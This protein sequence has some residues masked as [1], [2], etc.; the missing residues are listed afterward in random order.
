MPELWDLYDRRLMP[1]NETIERN[2]SMKMPKGKFHVV[3]NILSVNKE[4][5][6]LITKRHPDK[7]YG[8]MWE[9]SGG[10]VL[11]GER[12]LDGAVRELFEETGL[13][14]SADELSYMGQIIRE[15][16]GCIHNFYLYE[17]DFNENDI[18]LQEGETVGYMLVTPSE[19][20]VM[21]QSGEFLDFAFNRMRAV[22]GDIF[23]YHR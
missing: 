22:Y 19:I 21:S 8:N 23:F 1:L 14:A 2:D 5:K 17:G 20:E 3:V 7:P 9:I 16:S 18:T 12:P 10:S 11:S 13:K 15:R 4:G 6:I